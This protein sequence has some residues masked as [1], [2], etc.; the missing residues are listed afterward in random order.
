[1]ENKMSSQGPAPVQDPTPSFWRTELD[2]LD[3]HRSTSDLP[4][5]CDV[6]I[7]GAG[8]AGAAL[9]H[10]IYEDNPS[11]PSVVILEARQACSGATARN[12]GHLKPDTYLTLAKNVKKFG[13]RASVDVANFEAS[14]VYAM[15]ELVEK[16][17]IDCDFTMTRACDATL[18]ERL[19]KEIEDAHVELQKAGVANL[20]D[21]QFTSRANAERV[22]GVKGALNC[23]TFTAGHIWPYKMVM[24]LLKGVVAKGAN[25]QT[26]TPVTSVSDTA[27]SDGE[28]EVTTT[29]GTIRT[30]TILYATNAY[31]SRLAPQFKNKILPVRGICSRIVV[32]ED[33]KA[34]FLPY[35]Y[36]IRH[37]PGLYDYLIPRND[38]SI[39]VGGAKSLFWHDRKQW[40]GVF[41]DSKMI[42][43]AKHYFDGLMQRTFIGW[44]DSGAYTDKVWTGIMAYS[45]D[46]MP[47]VG[48]V[49]GKPGQM[50]LA[51]FSGHGMPLILLSAKAVV[52]MLRF[53]KSFEE[54][55]LPSPFKV[56][57][58]RLES[59][60]NAILEGHSEEP[61][62]ARSKL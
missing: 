36:S 45:S 26:H 8:F 43:P 33:R 17:K 54:S 24:H 9:A 42:E 5:E 2:E 19:A 30:K 1:M 21:V 13:A 35:T 44:E 62:A 3:N 55:G 14:Q 56:T 59:T 6:V 61:Y 4:A 40:Y 25:L 58:E 46:F 51:G 49:P 23:F 27:S 31:T 47:Y 29:R 16:E 57:K 10:Y 50:V 60:E 15:K 22:S 34:P 18:D 20:K 41:D 53:G 52:Q 7:I 39:I 37:G 32:P 11:P 38:G 48:D 12:G 28:W